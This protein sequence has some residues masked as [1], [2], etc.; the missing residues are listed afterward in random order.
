MHPEQFQLDKIQ[1]DQFSAFIYFT[2]LY[3][4]LARTKCE[5]PGKD[6]P[7]KNSTWSN[8]NGRLLPIIGAKMHNIWQ[9]V[10]N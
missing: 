8:L 9:T 7:W 1:N 5:I 3:S 2:M 4:I 10:A 6:M